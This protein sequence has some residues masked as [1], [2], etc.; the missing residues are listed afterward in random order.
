ME[1]AAFPLVVPALNNF[2]V[3]TSHHIFNSNLSS[4]SFHPLVFVILLFIRLK[5]YFI[6]QFLPLHLTPWN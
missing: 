1:N 6:W 5:N 4:F 2:T 3:I